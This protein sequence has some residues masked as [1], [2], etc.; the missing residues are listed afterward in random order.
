[1]LRSPVDP[2]SDAPS[3]DAA[4]ANVSCTPLPNATTPTH[5][6]SIPRH[7]QSRLVEFFANQLENP[8]SPWWGGDQ[9]ALLKTAAKEAYAE[10]VEEQG[11]DRQRWNWGELHALPLTHETFGTSCIAPI[12][13]LFIRGTYPTGGGFGVY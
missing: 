5:Q 12:E 9:P 10:L 3:S 8:D 2:P 6:G 11:A 13:A 1:D 4:L 7:T